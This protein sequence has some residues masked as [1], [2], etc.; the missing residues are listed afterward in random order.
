M[1]LESRKKAFEL[2][3]Q[4]ELETKLREQEQSLK[5]RL[6]GEINVLQIEKNKVS[7]RVMS[8]LFLYFSLHIFK[9]II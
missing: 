5:E 6:D 7:N 1:D 4:Q 3:L 9:Y 2:Q 8:T